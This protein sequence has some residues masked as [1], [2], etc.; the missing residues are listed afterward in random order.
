M[1]FPANRL[2]ESTR[3]QCF[4]DKLSLSLKLAE[5]DFQKRVFGGFTEF[6]MKGELREELVYRKALQFQHGEVS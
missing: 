1:H 2:Q 4:T 3:L 6:S 5:T